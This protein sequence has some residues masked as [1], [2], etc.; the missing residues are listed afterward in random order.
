MRGRVLDALMFFPSREFPWLPSDIGMPYTDVRFDAAD[1]TP[2]HGW[3]LPTA[4]ERVG[5]V[6]FA[7]GN[8]GNISD[9][10]EHL[11][12]LTAAGF[13]VLAF[14]YR[15]YGHSGGRPNEAG[16]Y[17]D[18]R[19]ARSV[20]L[21]QPGVDPA[22][23]FYLGES[24]GGGVVTE[25]ALAHPPAGVVLTSTFTS[26]RDVARKH[27]PVIPNIAV[28]DAFPTLRRI[29]VLATP[30]L[31][32][33]GANDELVPPEQARRLYEA[34]AQPKELHIFPGVGHNDVV[35]IAGK[36]W[37]E[38]VAAWARRVDSPHF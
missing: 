4:A 32:L 34:A 36:K 14:D 18:A 20:L 21:Q 30:L 28:P 29:P 2:L 5:H 25:L 1:G 6:L 19:A 35:S 16:T 9:R 37:I 3:W 17:A 13:D 7:H 33:H 11:A 27:Y 23:V 31:I 10:V 8:G 38:I 24:L 26:I 15:G 12:L 22:R